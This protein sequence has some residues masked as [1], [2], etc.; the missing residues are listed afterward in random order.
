[1]E[2]KAKQ[3]EKWCRVD[4]PSALEAL[5]V[6]IGQHGRSGV[7]LVLPSPFQQREF[8]RRQLRDQVDVEPGTGE[9]RLFSPSAVQY[10]RG[11]PIGTTLPALLK[12][13]QERVEGAS[14]W[15]PYL[16]TLDVFTRRLCPAGVEFF[17][18]MPS[19]CYFGKMLESGRYKPSVLFTRSSNPS[20]GA[21][22]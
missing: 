14:S 2:A 20:W 15:L 22:I 9:Q 13:R 1:M 17:E 16:D 19:L 8:L 21:R 11:T 5:G 6:C 3:Q 12:I 4:G 7:S 10:L 18:V